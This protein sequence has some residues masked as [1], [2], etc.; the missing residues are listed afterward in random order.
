MFE[1]PYYPSDFH[2]TYSYGA[3]RDLSDNDNNFKKGGFYSSP[4]KLYLIRIF[5]QSHKIHWAEQ[6]WKE[7]QAI[8]SMNG[9]PSSKMT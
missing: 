6:R 9:F 4:L 8:H 2:T 3:H 1:V 5:L 7:S